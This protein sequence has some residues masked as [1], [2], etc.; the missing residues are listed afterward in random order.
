[1]VQGRG[2]SAAQQLHENKDWLLR[3][4]GSRQRHRSRTI[5]GC[6]GVQMGQ[7]TSCIPPRPEWAVK[8]FLFLYYLFLQNYA[9]TSVDVIQSMF[10]SRHQEVTFFHHSKAKFHYLIAT[11]LQEFVTKK[12]QTKTNHKRPHWSEHKGLIQLAQPELRHQKALTH[13]VKHSSQHKASKPSTTYHTITS[14]RWLLTARRLCPV[15]STYINQLYN[16]HLD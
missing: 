1:M 3:N 13:N 6:Y 11:R 10:H 15:S 7:S 4:G 14:P 16:S 12:R 2:G 5:N 9:T 8:T